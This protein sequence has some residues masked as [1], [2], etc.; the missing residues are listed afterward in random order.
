MNTKTLWPLIAVCLLSPTIGYPQSI[1]PSTPTSGLNVYSTTE[2]VTNKVWID[3]KLIYRKVVLIGTLPNTYFKQVPHGLTNVTFISVTGF[4]GGTQPGV[5]GAVQ[6]PFA[7]RVNAYMISLWVDGEYVRVDTGMDRTSFTDA[8]AI[9][10][11]T[12]N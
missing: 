6:L 10:E 2:T 8:F 7:H 3:G 1:P 11:Y 12:K 4:A 9:L 5:A